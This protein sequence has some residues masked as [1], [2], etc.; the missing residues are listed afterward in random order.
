[1]RGVRKSSPGTGKC[2]P[3]PHGEL[4][5]FPGSRTDAV[6]PVE[7]LGVVDEN[8]DLPAAFPRGTHSCSQ[9]RGLQL[10]QQVPGMVML[11][12]NV[13]AVVVLCDRAST[14]SF[15]TSSLSGKYSLSIR[16]WTWPWKSR[17]PVRFG[18]DV[19]VRDSR[20]WFFWPSAET[21]SSD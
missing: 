8:P 7:P 2:P 1:M 6:D 12:R 9:V 13:V 3:E 18:D 5:A 19:V 21:S 11:S 17:F 16:S 15:L 20:T 4:V 14:S 10:R